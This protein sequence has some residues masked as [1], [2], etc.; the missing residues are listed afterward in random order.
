V[1]RRGRRRGGRTVGQPDRP[2]REGKSIQPQEEA[3]AELGSGD[4]AFW[5]RFQNLPC[6]TTPHDY[7]GT[8]LLRSRYQDADPNNTPARTQL[9]SLVLVLELMLLLLLL[10]AL[11]YRGP[12][13]CHLT[14]WRSSR[15]SSGPTEG[16]ACVCGCPPERRAC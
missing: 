8:I 1:G 16:P 5:R 2:F 10:R 14:C 13:L 11:C 12:N 15:S 3:P 6:S 7:V 9:L 4:S